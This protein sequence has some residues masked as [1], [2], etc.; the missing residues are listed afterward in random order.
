MFSA[1]EYGS[2]V[3]HVRGMKSHLLT[4]ENYE[5]LLKTE[6]IQGVLQTL[7]GTFYASQTEALAGK[8][9]DM[10]MFEK[11]LWK[12]FDDV[13]RRVLSYASEAARNFLTCDYNRYEAECLKAIFRTVYGGMPLDEALPQMVPVGRFTLEFCANLLKEAIPRKILEK[14]VENMALR[15]ELI[16]ALPKSEKE[17]TP[18]PIEIALDNF[19]YTELWG[20][21]KRLEQLERPAVKRIIGTE[22]DVN[23]INIVLRAKLTGL[24]PSAINDLLIPISFRL[25]AE[26]SK[27]VHAS[28]VWEALKILASGTYGKILRELIAVCEQKNSVFLAE[29]ALKRLLATENLAT[30]M[31]YP[32]Q[33]GILLAYLNLKFY[34]TKD[35]RAVLIGKFNDIS[36]ER[37]AELLVLYGLV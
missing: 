34:E 9:F 5:T 37:I 4:T 25:D 33:V 6:G 8:K 24:P 17:G 12:D 23:N 20:G 14:A 16:R 7:R 32:F 18:L 13:Y 2:A 11:Q 3:A 15:Q 35:L 31:G 27:S 29:M 19:Y 22:I 1:R 36:A 28:T 30:F 21:I 10:I 26:L